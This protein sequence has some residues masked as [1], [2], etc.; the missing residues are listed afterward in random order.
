MSDKKRYYCNDCNCFVEENHRCQ[1][2]STVS[3]MPEE[4][5]I[6]ATREQQKKIDDLQLKLA[7][8]DDALN[9]SR[10]LTDA[11]TAQLTE[12]NKR[13]ERMIEEKR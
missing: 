12:A 11:L 1:Q 2:W 9:A 10:L 5:F 7:I 13:I 3:S 4:A 6:L 8:K